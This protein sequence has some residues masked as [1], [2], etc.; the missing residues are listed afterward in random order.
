MT[1]KEDKILAGVCIIL[2]IFSIA[3]FSVIKGSDEVKKASEI[4]S[5]T[6]EYTTGIA[7]NMNADTLYDLINDDNESND[8]YILSIRNLEHYALGH[9]PGAVNI[10]LNALF[11]EENLAKL[12]KDRQIVVYC[13]TGHT[14]SQAT[15]LLN[16]NGYNAV[17]LTWGM[18]SWTN[19]SIVAVN[20]Y[21]NKTSAANDYPIATG[22][23]S[24][25]YSTIANI[26]IFS[27]AP[28]VC[29]VPLFGFIPSVS[30]CGGD[31]EPPEENGDT[32]GISI[33]DLDSLREATYLSL[34]QGKPP[35]I[36]APD[37]YANLEDG[38]SSNDPFILDVRKTEHY[39][40]G[41]IP[42]AINIGMTSL[43]TDIGLQKLP[44]DKNKQI[45]VVCYTGHTASQATALLNL[46]GYNATAL[47]WGMC[48]WSLDA[49][50]TVGKCFDMISD[51]HNYSFSSGVW[52]EDFR[53]T[54]YDS[55]NKGK[56]IAIT[57]ESLYERLNDT[58]L[59]NDPFVLSLRKAQDYELGHIPGAINIGI[60]NLFTEENLAKLPYNKQI[61]VVCYTGHTASQATA[62][63]NTLGYNAT[64]LK[65]GMCSWTTNT[66]VNVN[67]CFDQ[68]T[69]AKDY[70][71][72]VGPEPGGMS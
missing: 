38:N 63:L 50:V 40:I 14:A 66:T 20:K 70:P 64:A 9:I 15:A 4:L 2:L 1:N 62:L 47:M 67:Q 31:T 41:H 24:G 55:L 19:D 51:S 44:E 29:I 37:L 30:A 59:T 35:V 46:N 42:G 60:T 49:N 57:A 26:N 22:S 54:I 32:D 28:N 43:F 56:P 3:F 45:V 65:W 13:Y 34:N 61:V 6:R 23:E 48:S 8:P 33:D 11:K 21:Y 25:A 36:K 10:P 52:D 27:I 5:A 7:T 53:E 17:C 12:T 58:D 18:C 72:I 71:Y 16:V 68:T 69:A 39:D